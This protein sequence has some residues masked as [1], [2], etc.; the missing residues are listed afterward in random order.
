MLRTAASPRPPWGEQQTDRFGCLRVKGYLVRT[1]SI[2]SRDRRLTA[3]SEWLRGAPQR[4]ELP[5]VGTALSLNGAEGTSTR[6]ELVPA[7]ERE[8]SRVRKRYDEARTP[9]RRGLEAGM[10]AG[11]G[12]AELEPLMAQN[13]PLSIKRRI[14]AELDKPWRQGVRRS[15][16]ASQIW[17]NWAKSGPLAQW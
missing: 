8:G 11:Q 7:L 15:P 14:D 12:K 6:A 13:G 5:D 2:C 17:Y 16:E 9:F 4:A 10:I 3:K 1:A